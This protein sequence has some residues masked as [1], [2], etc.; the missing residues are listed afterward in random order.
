MTELEELSVTINELNNIWPLLE[1]DDKNRIL[2]ERDRLDELASELAYKTINQGEPALQAAIDSLKEATQL[3]NDVKKSIESLTVKTEK[4][5][6]LV[7][8]TS[9]AA[10]KVASLIALL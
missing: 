5:A 4:V 9:K 8:K 3:A 7:K 6:K 1:G 2:D 10:G